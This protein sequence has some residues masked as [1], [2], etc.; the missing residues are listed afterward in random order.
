MIW[1]ELLY[2]R[3]IKPTWCTTYFH[4]IESLYLNMFQ[5]Y[6]QP[7]IGWQ[8]SIYVTVGMCTS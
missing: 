3:I 8:Q 1:L 6:L 2:V 4:F 5:A 7:I